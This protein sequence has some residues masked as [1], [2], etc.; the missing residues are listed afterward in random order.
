MLYV[1]YGTD[2]EKGRQAF[3]AERETLAA[4][5]A[6]TYATLEGEVTTEFL[7]TTAASRGLFGETTLFVFDCVL[8]KKAEQEV[9]ASRAAQLAASPNYFLVFEPSLDKK[10]GEEIAPHAAKL[11]EY[12]LKKKEARLTFNIFALGD[13]LGKR[14]KKELW[15]LYQGA[16]AAGLEGE[17]IAGTLMWAVRNIALMKNARPGDDVGLSPFV[18][19]KARGFA[20]HY[21]PAEIAGLSRGLTTLYHEAHRGG[22][23]MDIALERFVLTL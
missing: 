16:R 8:D 23:P 18:A 11:E 10:L 20:A 17:E 5:T 3:R 9:F 22:E 12:V 13:A 15:V 19:K 21:T 7:D 1:F 14:D 6:E 4:R 2:R